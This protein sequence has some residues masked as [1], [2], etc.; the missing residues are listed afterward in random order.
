MAFV[1]DQICDDD[2]GQRFRIPFGLRRRRDFRKVDAVIDQ[3]D[4]H[5]ID[6]LSK[7]VKHGLRIG[8]QNPH[9]PMQQTFD[10]VQE[11]MVVL[12]A[13]ETAAAHDADRNARED[14]DGC[15]DQVGSRQEKMGDHGTF[16]PEQ[17]EQ[18]VGG[19][20]QPPDFSACVL[21][22]LEREGWTD[23]ANAC[24]FHCFGLDAPLGDAVN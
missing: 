9:T 21:P 13:I 20:D 19:N 14:R 1:W 17:R 16:R 23:H 6:L 5:G 18:L 8:D 11:W 2:Q 10:S 24:A 22:L 15:A 12:I 7:L 4:R 3:L